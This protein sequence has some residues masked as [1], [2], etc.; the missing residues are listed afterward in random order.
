[1]FHT[2]KLWKGGANA[3]LEF[4]WPLR[5]FSVSG[6]AFGATTENGNAIGR[7]GEMVTAIM[8]VGGGWRQLPSQVNGIHG[9]DGIFVRALSR[10]GTYE[11]CLVETK[12]SRNGNAKRNYDPTQ[13]SNKKVIADLEYLKAEV[14]NGVPY[15]PHDIADEII[16]KL[17]DNSCFVQKKLFTHDFLTGNTLVYP[18]DA[19]GNLDESPKRVKL[20]AEPQHKYLFEALAIGFARLDKFGKMDIGGVAMQA[21]PVNMRPDRDSS[22]RRPPSRR[23][24][25]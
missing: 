7:I 15:L 6:A 3:P 13:M 20:I 17:N 8:M 19:D 9:I 25:S 12:T 24:T 14:F 21:L 11:A 4:E 23:R 16:V 10:P 5:P 18:I 22:T 1:M 2:L